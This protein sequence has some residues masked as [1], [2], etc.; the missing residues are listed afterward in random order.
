VRRQRHI[1]RRAAN[2][3]AVEQVSLHKADLLHEHLVRLHRS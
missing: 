3:A 2:L 1:L